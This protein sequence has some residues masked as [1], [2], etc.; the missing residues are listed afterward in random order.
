MRRLRAWAS[1]PFQERNI[2]RPRTKGWR[3]RH[4]LICCS[5]WCLAGA[6][7][8]NVMNDFELLRCYA[9]DRSEAAFAELVKRYIDFVYSAAFRQVGGDAHL[10]DDVTQSVFVD[11]ARKAGS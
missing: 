11:L 7:M 2:Q 10:A 3:L 4:T 9:E 6:K 1:D 8:W 5:V